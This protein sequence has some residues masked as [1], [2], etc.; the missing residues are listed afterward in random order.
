MRPLVFPT[1]FLRVYSLL[2]LMVK[3]EETLQVYSSTLYLKK[4]TVAENP[5]PPSTKPTFKNEFSFAS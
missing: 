1:L 5:H 4:E 2:L 3:P